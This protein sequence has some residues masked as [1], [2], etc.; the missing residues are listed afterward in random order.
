[1]T[2]QQQEMSGPTILFARQP[3][4]DRNL[5][6]A[7]YEL[8]FRSENNEHMAPHSLN[9]DLATNEVMLN[10][11]IESTIQEVCDGKPAFINMTRQRLCEPIPF[12]PDHVVLEL[13]ETIEWDS[14][15][16]PVLD[17]LAQTGYRLALD[18][19]VI[20]NLN[21]PL[22]RYADIIKLEYPACPAEKL[23]GVVRQLKQ[24]RVQVLA[25]KLE[26]REDVRRCMDAGCDFF[27][28]YFLA[29][30]EVVRGR[31]MPNNRL[32]VLRL[33]TA[34]N[35]PQIE[36]QEIM[37]L[38]RQDSFFSIRLLRVVNSAALRRSAEV[39]SINTA[40]MLLGLNRIRA[41]ISMLALAK[42]EDK[43]HALQMLAL[44]RARFAE[45]IAQRMG[46][47][48]KDAAFT[49]GLFSCIDA[50]FDTPMAELLEQIP[51]HENLR[52]ALLEKEGLLGLILDT[53][54]LYERGKWADLQLSLLK[55]GGVAAADLA[56]DYR[57]SIQWAEDVESSS[58]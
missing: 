39:T 32:S 2:D 43:P 47:K 12:A 11:F 8:L 7:A 42:L 50:F 55:R 40:V 27:Q 25:E 18:D 36:L 16:G 30:P 48:D 21:S 56:V 1:M 51:L 35:K 20:G 46:I 4:F 28:G 6:V 52:K 13:L 3:I 49:T 33:L 45:L 31:K 57:S 5:S 9:G 17:Q 19:F 58:S 22:I 29:R 53:V 10:A 41:L 24:H 23:S 15:L 37:Q 54:L 44:T 14:S 34:V 26:T 38:I